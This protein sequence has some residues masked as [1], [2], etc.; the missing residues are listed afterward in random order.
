MKKTKTH[1]FCRGITVAEMFLVVAILSLLSSL[2]VDKLLEGYEAARD[3]D[4]IALLDTAQNALETYYNDNNAYPVPI[5]STK[6][7]WG[8]KKT[9]CSTNYATGDL[10]FDN[11]SSG[12]FLKELADKDY[13]NKGDWQDPLLTTS[14]INDQWNCRYVVPCS[15][16]ATCKPQQY[17]LHCNLEQKKDLEKHD[18]GLGDDLYEVQG[19]TQTPWICPESV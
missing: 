14:N 3:T 18:Q 16:S 13:I 15:N 1:L 11:S 2:I 12:T 5:D 8:Y 9:D 17:L 10:K 4:R 19:G 6:G 7:D